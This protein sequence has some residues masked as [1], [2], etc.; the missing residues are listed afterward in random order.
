MN[1]N[2]RVTSR[3][4]KCVLILCDALKN[5]TFKSVTSFHIIGVF[6]LL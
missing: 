3:A 4:G 2:V 5:L 6:T 1:E